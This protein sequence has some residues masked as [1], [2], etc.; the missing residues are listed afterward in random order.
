MNP[1]SSWPAVYSGIDAST[2]TGVGEGV[3]VGVAVG[4]RGVAVGGRG[5]GEGVAVAVG[6]RVGNGVGVI[7]GV[8]VG[9]TGVGVLVAPGVA[10]NSDPP[11][12]HAVRASETPETSATKKDGR[13]ARPLALNRLPL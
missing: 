13:Q 5:V 10:K 11:D 8:A 3:G 7:V 12:E 9:R 2:G 1:G 6:V 4:G